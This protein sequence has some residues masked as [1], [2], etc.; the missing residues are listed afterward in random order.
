M[1]YSCIGQNRK[2]DKALGIGTLSGAAS[3]YSIS[4][5]ILFDD[6]IR[7]QYE[8]TFIYGFDPNELFERHIY[9]LKPGVN[10]YFK[11]RSMESKRLFFT[12]V[13]SLFFQ[14]YYMHYDPF[15]GYVLPLPYERY[16]LGAMPG[17]AINWKISDRFCSKF[18]Y[19]GAPIYY[20]KLGNDCQVTNN[21]CSKSA[22][23]KW[24]FTDYIELKLFFKLNK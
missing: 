23:K 22:V 3:K 20:I 4:G 18:G 17:L 13:V 12:G 14:Y 11:K 1:S 2:F 16:G 19:S 9:T 5:S 21:D 6:K 24:D 15:G 7:Y 10:I 8:F